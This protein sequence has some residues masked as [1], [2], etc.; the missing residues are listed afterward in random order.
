MFADFS[1]TKRGGE[2]A[3]KGKEKFEKCTVYTWL[4]TYVNLVPAYISYCLFLIISMNFEQE[5]VS[6]RLTVEKHRATNE[7]LKRMKVSLPV[8]PSIIRLF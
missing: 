2:F 7:N 6:L 1:W 3:I 4:H 8:L 5:L